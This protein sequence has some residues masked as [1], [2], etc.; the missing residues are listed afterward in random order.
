MDQA[1][2]RSLSEAP[3]EPCDKCPAKVSSTALVRNHMNDYSVPTAYGFR[4][5]LGFVD[6]V[7]II[8]G[9]CWKSAWAIVAN[10]SNARGRNTAARGAEERSEDLGHAKLCDSI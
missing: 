9:A 4:D 2:L 6:Q 5:V 3:F 10:A 1:A 8:C 7:A